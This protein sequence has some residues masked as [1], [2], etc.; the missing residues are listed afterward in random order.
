MLLENALFCIE[1]SNLDHC[2]TLSSS[3]PVFF[4]I[5]IKSSESIPFAGV[6]TS[7]CPT[8]HSSNVRLFFFLVLY[9]VDLHKVLA[10]KGNPDDGSAKM[11]NC[12]TQIP[13]CYIKSSAQ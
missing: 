4:F 10:R 1:F 12:S 11:R 7:P 9:H 8:A 13:N 6:E 2:A 3:P 5:R